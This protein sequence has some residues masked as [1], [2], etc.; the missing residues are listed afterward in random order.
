[1]LDQQHFREDLFY[2][3]NSIQIE[4][5]PLRDRKEDI[6]LLSQFFLKKYCTQYHKQDLK[7]DERALKWL[8]NHDWPGNIR[9]LEHAMEKAVILS[10]GGSITVEHLLPRFSRTPPGQAIETF[11][12]EEHERLVIERALKAEGGNVSAASKKLGINRS[13]LYQKMKKYGI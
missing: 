2:R 5:P 10:E 13:T 9:E 11:N 6:P 4:I 8:Q 7:I 12:L 1:M 3:I